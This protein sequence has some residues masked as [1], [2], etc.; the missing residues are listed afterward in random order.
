MTINIEKNGSELI[1]H[2]V[3][4]IN[5]QTAPQLEKEVGDNLEGIINLIFDFKEV[6]YVSSAGLRVLLKYD[7]L[8]DGKGTLKVINVCS[9]VKE[10]FDMTGF[11]S[12]LTL[13]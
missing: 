3:G 2:V 4:S 6:D 9:D 12:I 7:N 5:T 8:M 10:V 1:I 13:E 11:S